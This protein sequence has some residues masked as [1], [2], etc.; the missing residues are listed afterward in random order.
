MKRL[1]KDIQSNARSL[2]LPASDNIYVL[3][4]PDDEY[5]YR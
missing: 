3:P 2:T 1:N 5:Q 4:I